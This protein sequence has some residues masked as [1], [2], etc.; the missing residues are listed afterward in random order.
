MM[1][2]EKV[3][4]PLLASSLFALIIS[5]DAPQA[6]SNHKMAVCLQS[7]G[8]GGAGCLPASA[9]GE[10]ATRKICLDLANFFL[11]PLK[12]LKLTFLRRALPSSNNFQI[13][14]SESEQVQRGE[15]RVCVTGCPPTREG[16][17]TQLKRADEH[18]QYQEV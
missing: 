8:G 17:L 4:R 14:S 5:R 15:A 16:I 6:I 12:V 3:P 1:V 9:R 10:E 13:G 11:W 18:H 7:S 2:A